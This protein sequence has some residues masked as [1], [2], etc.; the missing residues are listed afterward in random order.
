[1][2]KFVQDLNN[3]PRKVLGWKSPAE[4]F[5]GQSLHLI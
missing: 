3:R 1:I 4:V 2:A 5:F